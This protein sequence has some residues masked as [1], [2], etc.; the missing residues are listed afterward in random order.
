MEMLNSRSWL[1]G[2]Q[3]IAHLNGVLEPSHPL[4]LGACGLWSGGMAQALVSGGSP[5]PKG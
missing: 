4:G 3:G 2:E 1:Q 5:V